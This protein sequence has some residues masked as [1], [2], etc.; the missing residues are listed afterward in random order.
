M[1]RPFDQQP[2]AIL[3][4]FFNESSIKM[5]NTQIDL[6]TFENGSAN[7]I[8]DSVVKSRPIK[9]KGIPMENL[10]GFCADTCN[11]M[12]GRNHSVASLLKTGYPWIMTIK[13]SYQLI[14]LC[15]SYVDC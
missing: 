2:L 12:F 5:E 1:K 9:E 3:G 6:I 7:T 10:V 14:H 15:S 4:S 11:V 8:F 13:C